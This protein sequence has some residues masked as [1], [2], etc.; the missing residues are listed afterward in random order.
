[1]LCVFV[2]HHRDCRKVLYPW[3][4]ERLGNCNYLDTCNNV[5]K[6]K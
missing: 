5:L 4:D 6:C 1:M 3:T 2:W